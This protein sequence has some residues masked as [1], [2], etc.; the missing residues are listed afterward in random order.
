MGAYGHC[1]RC[2]LRCARAH[3]ACVGQKKKK[4]ICGEGALSVN[5]SAVWGSADI[6]AQGPRHKEGSVAVVVCM[7]KAPTLHMRLCL[8]CLC[9]RHTS[10]GVCLDAR[11]HFNSTH[12]HHKEDD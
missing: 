7:P 8:Q 6:H 5:V 9:V 11:T 3:T 4:K 1:L 10:G 12:H 2:M